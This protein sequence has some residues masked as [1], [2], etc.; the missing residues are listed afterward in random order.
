[1]TLSI[2]LQGTPCSRHEAAVQPTKPFVPCVTETNFEEV[3]VDDAIT[4]PLRPWRSDVVVV[5]TATIKVVSCSVADCQVV[6]VVGVPIPT[7]QI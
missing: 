7:W 3:D 2:S 6:V 1:V 4:F 5:V